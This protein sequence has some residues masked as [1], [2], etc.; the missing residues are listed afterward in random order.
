MNQVWKSGTRSLAQS[1]GTGLVFRGNHCHRQSEPTDAVTE[2]WDFP[3][4]TQFCLVVKYMSFDRLSVSL[5]AIQPWA[6]YVFS[7][8]S[9][10]K[11]IPN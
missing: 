5:V 2:S 9:H 3:L 11:K 10:M 4:G 7:C 6:K 8:L 1:Q